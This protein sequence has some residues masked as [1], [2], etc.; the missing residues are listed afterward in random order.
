[1]ILEQRIRISSYEMSLIDRI[2]RRIE[3]IFCCETYSVE[4]FGIRDSLKS[5][6]T[7]KAI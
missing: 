1:M 6:F 7:Q 3:V 5:K 2:F 4:R